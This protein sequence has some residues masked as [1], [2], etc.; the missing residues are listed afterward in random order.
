MKYEMRLSNEVLEFLRAM[1][2]DQRRSI[3]YRLH[4]LCE[5]L[6]GD[7]KKLAATLPAYRC[8][9][10]V[11][12]SSPRWKIKPS[13]FSPS[14][15]VVML[16]SETLTLEKLAQ[17]VEH[18]AEELTRLNERLEDL[19]D[20]HDLQAAMVANASRPLHVWETARQELGL[21]DEESVRTVDEAR[22]SE[23]L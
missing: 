21:T 12:V 22:T 8:E 4:L 2:G 10:A 17:T 20:L 3:G 19:E 11:F 1:P 9:L 14:K 13:T 23:L 5:D 7:V 15:T 18:Q 6:N 16:M